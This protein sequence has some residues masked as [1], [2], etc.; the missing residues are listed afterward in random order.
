MA[1]NIKHR[2]AGKLRAA[3]TL[4][5]FACHLKNWRSV[6]AAYRRRRPIASPLQLRNGLQIE[7]GSADDA[8]QVFQEVFVRKCY[9]PSWFY[10]PR[11]GD[12]VVDLG[13]NIGFFTLSVAG[14]RRGLRCY[15]FEPASA[16]RSRLSRNVELNHLT[17]FVQIHPFA[18]GGERG[19]IELKSGVSSIHTSLL[20]ND[21]IGEISGEPVEVISLDD[22]LQRTGETKIDLLKIDIEGAE[23]DTFAK[24]SPATLAGVQ[25]IAIEFH[26]H[27]CPGARATVEERLKES[28]FDRMQVGHLCKDNQN[29]ILYAWRRG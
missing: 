6:W 5:Q 9:T 1:S 20:N 17:E 10:Q 13:A 24:V 16:T 25:R 22:A 29:G 28:G 18:V 27:F 21:Q 19:K 15:C 3:R 23:K 4:Y 2:V 8:V 14:V 7:F 26:D 11:V 12:V